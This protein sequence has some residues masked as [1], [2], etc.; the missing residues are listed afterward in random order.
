M[1]K[2]RAQRSGHLQ[3]KFLVV[4]LSVYVHIVVYIKLY[5]SDSFVINSGLKCYA[6]HC[7]FP[8]YN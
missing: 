3:L 7:K 5:M 1:R 2:E 8:Y 4:S 6:A